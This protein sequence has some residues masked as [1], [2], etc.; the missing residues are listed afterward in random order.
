MVSIVLM[1]SES[2]EFATN[3]SVEPAENI[4][5]PDNY[6]NWAFLGSWAIAHAEEKGSSGMHN[7]FTESKNIEYYKK[8]GSFPDGAV[9]VKELLK[10]QTRP[11]TTGIA[12]S[13]TEIEGWFVMVKDTQNRYPNNPLWGNGWGWAYFEADSP[14]KTVST[15]FRVDCLGCHTPVQNTDWLFIDGYPV[16]NDK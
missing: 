13:A 1:N 4:V 15:N 6:R 2:T 11:M 5:V 7:V 10:A 9:I 16:L 3:S 14:N 12:S 8:N